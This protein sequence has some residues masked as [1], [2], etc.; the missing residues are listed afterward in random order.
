MKDGNH[1]L[2]CYSFK[3]DGSEYCS[4]H[5]EFPN[6]SVRMAEM[7]RTMRGSDITEE[8]FRDKYFP[9]STTAFGVEWKPWIQ[10]VR[11]QVHC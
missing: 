10:S 6:M 4:L 3:K 9:G 2:Q 7:L 8:M 5:E 1:T 11:N